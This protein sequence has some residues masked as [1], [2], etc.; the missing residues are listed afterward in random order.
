MKDF[1]LKSFE[2]NIENSIVA[3]T[4]ECFSEQEFFD[5]LNT[6]F[7]FYG[8]SLAIDQLLKFREVIFFRKNFGVHFK[9]MLKENNHPLLHYTAFEFSFFHAGILDAQYYNKMLIHVERFMPYAEFLE[10]NKDGIRF[11]QRINANQYGRLKINNE[12]LDAIKN[13]LLESV[14][15]V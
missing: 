12:D 11:A 3:K 4:I 5:Y 7:S 15:V 10:R 6:L 9:K 14:G 1:I 13:I 8:S 2:G